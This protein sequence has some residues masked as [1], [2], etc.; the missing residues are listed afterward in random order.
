MTQSHQL[1]TLISLSRL[2]IIHTTLGTVLQEGTSLKLSNAERMISWPPRT[3]HTAARSSRTN[4]FVLHQK[5][6]QKNNDNHEYSAPL[7]GKKK[8][9]VR[10]TQWIGFHYKSYIR[11]NLIH[12]TC[13]TS[14]LQ[15][16]KA[17]LCIHCLRIFKI[18]SLR[19]EHQLLF[20]GLALLSGS[21]LTPR[22]GF[23][24]ENIWM[25]DSGWC[26]LNWMN[27]LIWALRADF[28]KSDKYTDDHPR[29]VY[30]TPFFFFFKN[31]LYLLIC[32]KKS[33]WLWHRG[34]GE[35][36]R[37]GKDRRGKNYQTSN[38][39]TLLRLGR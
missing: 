36:E 9:K 29:T 5:K 25:C 23:S 26:K 20:V 35:R 4:A 33:S 14:V 3:R 34:Q 17:L 39:S 30:D 19:D 2:H 21:C 16:R 31:A 27:E 22:L 1:S 32:P 13:L 37:D 12:L 24:G 18:M 10:S 38:R 7:R 8:V 28:C 15:G 11:L 6:N